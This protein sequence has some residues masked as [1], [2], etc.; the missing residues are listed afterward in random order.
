MELVKIERNQI[1]GKT[2][3]TANARE[4][5]T[6]LAV[7]KDFSDWIKAQIKF[8]YY[9]ESMLF[10]YGPI[11]T[12]ALLLEGIASANS[13]P[14]REAMQVLRLFQ[15]D[16]IIPQEL[17]YVADAVRADLL[18]VATS[19]AEKAISE[20]DIQTHFF[21]Y[22]NHYLPNASAVK[23][24]TRLRSIPDGF[25]S[26]GGVTA[27]VEVKLDHFGER[28]LSQLLGYM[29]RY[30]LDIGIA[31]A[32]RCTLELPS[33]VKFVQV[34]KEDVTDPR[35]GKVHSYHESVLQAVI[36]AAA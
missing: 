7:K 25:V 20:L 17:A 13:M 12:G 8:D 27:P 1:A 3:Q 31:V 2:V 5:H 32:Q 14:P 6:F 21:K 9:I 33:T 24:A 16:G 15:Q 11:A 29:R 4:L 18:R 23:V 22:L 26:I 19:N 36:D 35:F 30:E 34:N 10:E 28:A